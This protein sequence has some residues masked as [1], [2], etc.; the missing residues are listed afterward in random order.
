MIYGE[1]VQRWRLA[2][3]A[4]LKK[5]PRQ[6]SEPPVHAS[7][8]HVNIIMHPDLHVNRDGQNCRLSHR[9]LPGGDSSVTGSCAGLLEQALTCLRAAAAASPMSP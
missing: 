8:F 4:V 9:G 7:I 2:Q 1:V 5:W 3:G 6:L